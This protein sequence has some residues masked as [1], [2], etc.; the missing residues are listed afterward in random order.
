MIPQD[1]QFFYQEEPRVYGDCTRACLAT[2]LN[3]PI[4]AVPHFL[5]VARGQVYEFYEGVDAF[6][7][8]RGLE[9]KYQVPLSDYWQP[10]G[11][12]VFHLISGQSPRS[13]KINHM[14]VGLNGRIIFDPHPSRVGLAGEPNEWRFAFLTSVRS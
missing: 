4:S 12:D 2:L 6:L 5:K 14:V 3:L 1:Q 7:E 13:P 10:G 9:I 8:E 11:P